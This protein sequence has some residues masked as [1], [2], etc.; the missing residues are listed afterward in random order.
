MNIAHTEH[1]SSNVILRTLHMYI[2]SLSLSLSLSLCLHIY[3]C[4]SLSL[5]THISILSTENKPSTVIGD[6]SMHTFLSLSLHVYKYIHTYICIYIH[7]Y[8]TH[9]A[10]IHQCNTA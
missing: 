4:L 5:Y 9:R 3:L 8:T 10:Q 6:S 7:G 2:I 1:K